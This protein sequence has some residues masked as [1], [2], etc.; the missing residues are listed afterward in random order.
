MCDGDFQLFVLLFF[1]LYVK[2]HTKVLWLP[3]N[4]TTQQQKQVPYVKTKTH[5]IKRHVLFH[6]PI[7]VHLPPRWWCWYLNKYRRKIRFR[8]SELNGIYH[9]LWTRPSRALQPTTYSRLH[10]CPQTTNTGAYW[11]FDW[12]L[13][14]KWVFRCWTRFFHNY[15]LVPVMRRH[16][17][18]FPRHDWSLPLTS[19]VNLSGDIFRHLRTLLAD[20]FYLIANI[21]D[22]KN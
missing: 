16:F 19:H 11:N 12:W 20:N 7:F 18:P 4:K 15:L 21:I 8:F 2:N 13:Y 5:N 6:Y 10:K 14:R 17:C 3:W 9:R 22:N 1:F